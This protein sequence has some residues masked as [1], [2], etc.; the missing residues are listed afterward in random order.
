M[1]FFKKYFNEDT[2]RDIE[3]DGEKYEVYSNPSKDTVDSIITKGF[4][5]ARMA[6][7]NKGNVYVWDGYIIHHDFLDSAPEY[8][9]IIKWTL[10][11]DRPR[12]EEP[13]WPNNKRRLGHDLFP[14]YEGQELNNV[15]FEK[16]VKYLKSVFPTDYFYLV[17]TKTI[18]TDKIKIGRKY[19]EHFDEAK[20]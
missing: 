16:A 15:A 3:Y 5:V 13:A 9:K 4:E 1:R 18:G 17:N 19:F 7:D 6:V 14:K 11:W 8:I 2:E 20:I 12:K 10:C